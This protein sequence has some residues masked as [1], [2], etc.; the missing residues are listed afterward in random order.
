MTRYSGFS[1]AIKKAES[2]AEVRVVAHVLKAATDGTWQAA[3]WWLE[4][5]RPHDYGRRD[6]V[7]VTVRQ[8]AQKLAAQGI[9]AAELVAE[10]ERIV[11]GG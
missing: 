1:D 8:Q 2:E 11:S 9:D 4:R 5:R 6:R 10:A 3:A 7:D